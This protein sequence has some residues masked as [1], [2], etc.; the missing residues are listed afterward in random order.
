M[1]RR[2]CPYV[3]LELL[4]RSSQDQNYFFMAIMRCH[5][6]QSQ[7]DKFQTCRRH[8]PSASLR[9]AVNSTA[10]MHKS[11]RAAKAWRLPANLSLSAFLMQ[12]SEKPTA[13]PLSTTPPSPPRGSRLEKT[14]QERERVGSEGRNF[15]RLSRRKK[16]YIQ[17]LSRK[18]PTTK[19]VTGPTRPLTG[20]S[21]FLPMAPPSQCSFSSSLRSVF[22][23]RMLQSVFTL[24]NSMIPVKPQLK[25]F[26][27]AL[28]LSFL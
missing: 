14:R 12:W 26:R 7:R 24:R 17:E 6:L 11:E 8:I 23:S 16:V 28:E 20:Q 27:K 9:Q 1:S 22:H 4:P 21:S 15:V 25:L 5:I 2:L 3:F 10:F 18:G 19:V 13:R